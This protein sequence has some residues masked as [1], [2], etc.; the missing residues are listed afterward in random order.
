MVEA[1]LKSGQRHVFSKRRFYLDEDSWT[2]LIAEAYDSR[3]ELWRVQEGYLIQLYDRPLPLLYS[4]VG[5]DLQARRYFMAFFS[6][7]DGPIDF[8]TEVRPSEFM[9]A[10]LRRRGR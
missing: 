1:T 2:A 3:D 4:E 8:E 10:S 6:N 7:E 9:P 5:Y